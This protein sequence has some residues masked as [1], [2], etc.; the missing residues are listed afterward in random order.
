M[1]TKSLLFKLGIIV[2]LITTGVLIVLGAY[3]YQTNYNTLRSELQENLELTA[4]RLSISLRAP[5]YTFHEEGVRDV[6]LSEMNNNAIAG[7]F[8]IETWENTQKYWYVNKN[9]EIRNAD[10][11][12]SGS[13]YV[14][15][16]KK[17]IQN[18]DEIGEI[19]VFLSTRQMEE[20]LRE[21]LFLKI[22]EIIVVDIVLVVLIIMFLSVRVFKP[23]LKLK[24]AALEIAKGNLNAKVNIKSKDE[25][26]ELASAFNQMTNDLKK[27]TVSIGE[28][29]KKIKR[30]TEELEKKNKELVETLEDFYTIRTGWEKDLEA[31]KLKAEN[32]KIRERL[33][34]LRKG[35][36]K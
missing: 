35:N 8:V 14:S 18:D 22:I 24:K 30:R 7:I 27:S 29:E 3:T 13:Q 9:G 5:L 32:K 16:S 15:I 12:I 6:I 23:I 33:D 19:R 21:T 28:L 25:L 26:G 11:I 34:K 4:D 2:V 1:F 10:E 17:I 36:R 31:G 20:N